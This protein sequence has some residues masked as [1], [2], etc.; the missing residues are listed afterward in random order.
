[1]DNAKHV[2]GGRAKGAAKGAARSAAIGAIADDEAGK[3]QVLEPLP[4]QWWVE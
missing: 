3:E 4:G 1:M 2:K